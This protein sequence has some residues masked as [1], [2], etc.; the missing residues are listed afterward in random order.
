[1]I[2]SSEAT[3]IQYPS[4]LWRFPQLTVFMWLWAALL[5]VRNFYLYRAAFRYLQKHPRAQVADVGAGEG[6]HIL[7]LAAYFRKAHFA[8]YDLAPEANKLRQKV[9]GKLGLANTSVHLLDI[10]EES[11]SQTADVILSSGVLHYLVEDVLSLRHMAQSLKPGGCLLLWVPV[12]NHFLL[13]F[14]AKGHQRKNRYETLAGRQR[15]Y[16]PEELSQK[17]KAAG[18]RQITMHRKM[19]VAGILAYELISLVNLWALRQK[20]LLPTIA[21]SLLIFP[22]LPF[23][24]LLYLLEIMGLRG[25][26]CN[27]VLIKASV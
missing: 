3:P 1:M 8:G 4:T 24:S 26:Y 5:Y 18:F 7:P 17:L 27:A 2:Y 22:L 11:L 23:T 21:I 20:K 16:T 15:I 12:H 10:E 6:Q 19:G 14:F 9:A 13:P 25:T